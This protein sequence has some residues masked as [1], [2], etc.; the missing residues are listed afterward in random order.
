MVLDDI[1]FW[2]LV[3]LWVSRLDGLLICSLGAGWEWV[4]YLVW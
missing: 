4:W 1:C 3:L 2:C